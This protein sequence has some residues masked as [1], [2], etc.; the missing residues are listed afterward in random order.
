[1]KKHF[2]IWSIVL[3]AFL[4]TRGQYDYFNIVFP[5]ESPN[6][7]GSWNLIVEDSTYLSIGGLA[8][9]QG[10]ILRFKRLDR[11]GN[12]VQQHD[13]LFIGQDF[14][15]G[16][17]DD[18][19]ELSDGTFVSIVN[20]YDQ[21]K[22]C[23]VAEYSPTF[24][25]VRWIPYLEATEDTD[26]VVVNTLLRVDDDYMVAGS[27]SFDTIPYNSGIGGDSYAMYLMKIDSL[28]NRIWSSFLHHSESM[29]FLGSRLYDL[30]DGEVLL[31]GKFGEQD[32]NDPLILK[33]DTAGTFF[34]EYIWGTNNCSEGMPEAIPNQDG[35]FSIIYQ[36]CV[37]QEVYQIVEIHRLVNLH[38]MIFNPITML[39]EYD[40]VL[41][42]P[43]LSEWNKAFGTGDAC[44]TEDGGIACTLLM[45]D[46]DYGEHNYILKLNAQ[47]EIEWLKEYFCPEGTECAIPVMQDIEPALDGGLIV[48]GF[49]NL[50][51]TLAQRHWLLKVD[52]CGDVENLGCSYPYVEVRDILPPKPELQLWPNPAND[53]I[54]ILAPKGGINLITIYDLSGSLIVQQKITGHGETLAIDI[55]AFSSGVYYVMCYSH[56]EPTGN[57]KFIK[58]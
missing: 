8:T 43:F 55:S 37:D 16:N 51:P 2:L 36:E 24:D 48:T 11:L 1:M 44:R 47:G 28:G 30:P 17:H 41:D 40:V 20:R 33:T 46:L 32:D 58:Q 42:I 22:I 26:Q 56:N 14:S 5:G 50:E 49:V 19:I 25:I 27:V 52:A 45:R 3:F 53:K 4:Q 9:L 34:S 13:S 38:F 21:T 15:T 57:L 10:D 6:G 7:E 12:L 39:P 23:G 35:K 29:T 31:T 54:T 18:V